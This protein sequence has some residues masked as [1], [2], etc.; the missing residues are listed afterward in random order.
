MRKPMVKRVLLWVTAIGICAAGMGLWIRS[1]APQRCR[2]P[3][4]SVLTLQGWSYGK[5]PVLKQHVGSWWQLFSPPTEINGPELESD[6][7]VLWLSGTPTLKQQNVPGST[8][9]E[10]RR[11]WDRVEVVDEQGHSLSSSYSTPSDLD[12][13]VCRSLNVI[14]HGGIGFGY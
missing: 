13:A 1:H 8:T 14:E 9:E 5:K 2:L 3:D 4:G 12:G 11:W 10:I 7:L 6:S